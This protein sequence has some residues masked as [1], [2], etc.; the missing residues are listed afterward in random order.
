MSMHRFGAVY[1]GIAALAA[2]L[3]AAA[4]AP[5]AAQ[6]PRPSPPEPGRIAGGVTIDGVDVAGLTRLEARARVLAER[7][8]PRRRPIELRMGPATVRVSPVRAGYVARVDYA[9]RG[10]MNFGRSRPPRVVDVPLR[11][12]VNR[13]RLLRILRWHADRVLPEPRDASVRFRGGRPHVTAPRLGVRLRGWPTLRAAEAAI[14]DR[15]ADRVAVPTERHRPQRTGVG[16][17]V[18]V[19]RGAFEARL[20][21]GERLMRTLPVAVGMASHPTPAGT[22]RI[23]NMER[24]PTWNPPDSRWAAGM[25]PVPPGPGNPLG[26][27][28]IG[29]NAPAIGLHGTPQP[30]TIGSRASHGCIRLRIPHAEWLYNLVR[31]GTPVHIV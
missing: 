31:I 22:F 25:G 23:V 27:R 21:R 24:N 8:A 16:F 11:Q 9:L 18:V 10:A 13:E 12:R 26:T 2:A 4:A 3:T 19:D 5:A 30:E 28:W 20:Y 6:D 1:A 29:I 17:S 14:L 15:P 7:V